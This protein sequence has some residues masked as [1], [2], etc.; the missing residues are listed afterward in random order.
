MTVDGLDEHLADVCLSLEAWQNIS[1]DYES[2]EDL[3]ISPESEISSAPSS[4][5]NELGSL[6]G[7]IPN[8]DSFK[9]RTAEGDEP[10]FD[11]SPVSVN[12]SSLLIMSFAVRH[13]LSGVALQDLLTLIT[14]HCPKPNNCIA[15]MN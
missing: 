15:E 5:L 9:E 11:G 3:P 2:H 1:F 10:L 6:C 4:L 13:Q 8:L 12:E 14:L 7:D